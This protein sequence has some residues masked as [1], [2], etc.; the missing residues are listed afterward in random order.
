MQWRL[1]TQGMK[2]N[3]TEGF[4]RILSSGVPQGSVLGPSLF[5]IFINDLFLFLK[6]VELAHFAGNNAKYAKNG[7]NELT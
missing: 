7:I 6:D 3:E 4:F 2:L 5:N 1:C